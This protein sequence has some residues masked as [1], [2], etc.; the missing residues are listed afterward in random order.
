MDPIE[1]LERFINE[2]T[3]ENA[4]EKEYYILLLR[5]AKGAEYIENPLIRPEDHAKG[6][7]LYDELYQK[8]SKMRG[9][10]S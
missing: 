3:W 8:A 5:I 9:T 2:T 1:E 6:I 10:I 4:G 7:K